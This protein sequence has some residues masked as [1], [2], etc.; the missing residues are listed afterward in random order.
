V[1]SDWHRIWP[2]HATILRNGR[3][4]EEQA[5]FFGLS[6]TDA[7]RI[8]WNYGPREGSFYRSENLRPTTVARA[9]EQ[10]PL[11]VA[12]ECCSP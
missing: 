11:V 1:P 12:N 4:F 7:D 5:E 2:G 8:F 3:Y 9:L 6:L 10:A